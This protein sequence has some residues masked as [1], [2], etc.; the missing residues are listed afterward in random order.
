MIFAYLGM[1][2]PLG[3]SYTVHSVQ[4]YSRQ[5]L[6]CKR[7]GLDYINHSRFWKFGTYEANR[8]LQGDDEEGGM[9]GDP[10]VDCLLGQ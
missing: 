2:R 4:E 9:V 5:T 8:G 7:F 6:T 1:M 3:R 10:G